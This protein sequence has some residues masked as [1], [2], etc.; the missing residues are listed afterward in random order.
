MNKRIIGIGIALLVGII[1]AVVIW[2]Q[3][4][5]N[6]K[7]ENMIEKTS[8]Y[9]NTQNTTQVN[10]LKSSNNTTGKQYSIGLNEEV[11]IKSP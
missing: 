4:H 10:V 5:D 8:V 6:S 3:I 11:S 1:A 7:S 9:S 2:T